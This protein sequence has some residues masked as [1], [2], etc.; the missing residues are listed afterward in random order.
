M[1]NTSKQFLCF[2][3]I[4]FLFHHCAKQSYVALYLRKNPQADNAVALDIQYKH[5]D[6]EGKNQILVDKHFYNLQTYIHVCTVRYFLRGFPSQFLHIYLSYY[7]HKIWFFLV[8]GFQ[9]ILL[10]LYHNRTNIST[11][12]HHWSIFYLFFQLLS[13]AQI[14]D[15]ITSFHGLDAQSS[16]PPQSIHTILLSL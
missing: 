3:N 13:N 9:M 14:F 8:T 4:S 11:I 12:P 6:L 1:A 7:I 16:T 2:C 5:C 10:R 15:A